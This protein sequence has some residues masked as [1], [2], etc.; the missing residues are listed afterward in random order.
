MGSAVRRLRQWRAE[1]HRSVYRFG[2]IQV[3]AP[4]WHRS[5]SPARLRREGAGA[6]PGPYDKSKRV[7]VCS[8]KV[9]YDLMNYREAN[10]VT[11]TAI[12]R[13]EQLYPLAGSKLRSVVKP[14]SNATS[15][16]WCQE[17]PQNMG[18]WTFIEP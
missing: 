3:A 12:I 8:G 14:F 4:E 17:E 2:R 9:Y 6:L 10:N 15:W 18:A 5:S 16:V 13:L 1:H 7:I 11:D